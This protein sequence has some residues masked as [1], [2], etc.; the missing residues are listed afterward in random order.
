MEV[1]EFTIEHIDSLLIELGIISEETIEVEAAWWIEATDGFLVTESSE[2]WTIVV[3][4]P[5]SAPAQDGSIP[6]EF[7]LEHVYPNPFNP[8][9]HIDF[10]LPEP[11]QVRLAVWDGSGRLLDVIMSERLPVGLHSISWSANNLPTGIYIFTL[12]ANGSRFVTKGMLIR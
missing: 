11:A 10:A 1:N 5:T 4:I 7:S 2:R 6:T 9:T 3:P 8:S 12:E